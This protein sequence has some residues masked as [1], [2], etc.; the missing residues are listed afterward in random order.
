MS[1]D[2]PRTVPVYT[3]EQVRAAERPLLEAGVPLMRRAATALAALAREELTDAASPRILVLAGSGDNGADALY[4]AADLAATAAVDVLPVG[5]RVHEAALAAALRAGARRIA[6]EEAEA[7]A[8]E[9]S[10]LLDGILGI[11]ASPDPALR[12]TA[13]AVVERLLRALPGDRMPR[14]VAVDVPSGLHPDTGDAD[15]VVLP[16]SLTVTFGA[17]KAGLVA[18]RGPGLAGRIALVDLG[19]GLATALPVGEASVSR[20][21]PAPEAQAP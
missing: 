14:I 4:A 16:A 5:G 7:A 6:P 1:R 3:A 19:L 12:G 17:V 20:V 15:D 9:A 21:V 11:G 13:R 8:S 18:G 10:L 2:V